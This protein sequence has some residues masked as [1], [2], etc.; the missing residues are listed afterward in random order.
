MFNDPLEKQPA[1]FARAKEWAFDN[2]SQLSFDFS[3]RERS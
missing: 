2:A 1:A 3:R